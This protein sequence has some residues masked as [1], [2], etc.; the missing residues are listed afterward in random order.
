MRKKV[1]TRYISGGGLVFRINTTKLKNKTTLLKLGH[2][3]NR[4]IKRRKKIA[5]IF[6]SVQ[7]P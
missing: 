4:V 6:S 2:G 7:P 1:F 3:T 5:E